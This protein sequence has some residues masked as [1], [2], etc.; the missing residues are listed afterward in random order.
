MGGFINDAAAEREW[1]AEKVQGWTESV[2]VLAG[3]AHKHL[4][5]VYVGLKNSLQQEWAFVQRLTPGVGGAFG[6]V[7][8]AL[9]EIFFP[10]FFQGLLERLPTRE[11]TRLPV[12]Q[13]GLALP[14]LVETAP[15]NWTA[16]CVIIGHLV[17]AIRGKVVF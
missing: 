14:D 2:N 16:Y 4:Q 13:A 3:V 15:E 10:A 11:N 6:P 8:E 17:A 5:S 1:L 9:Q 12:K 7:E